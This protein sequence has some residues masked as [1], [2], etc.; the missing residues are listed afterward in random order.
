[1]N[2]KKRRRLRIAGPAILALLA[3]VLISAAPNTPPDDLIRQGNKFVEKVEYE[4]A[5]K[6]YQEAEERGPDPGLIAFNKAAAYWRIGE[7]RIAENHY[8][9]AL[10]DA[11][12][13]IE[14]RTR[15]FYDLGNCLLV[16]GKN[17]DYRLLREA[18]RCYEICL[19]LATEV[20]LRKMATHNLKLAKLRWSEARK[21]SSNP[22]TPNENEPPDTPRQPDQKKKSNKD[23]KNDPTLN[24]DGKDPTKKVDPKTVKE[25]GPDMVEPKA[26]PNNTNEQPRPGR[27]SVPVIP[28]KD[29]LKSL[30][31][32][33]AHAALN[34]VEL[35]LIQIRKRLRGYATIPE[36][37][38]GKD[39]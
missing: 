31:P 14:R 2:A 26:D 17:T 16:Q 38:S 18:I 34:E 3:A 12:A 25:K 1:M 8:R 22:P 21:S 35:R 5:L 36:R 15:A 24:N 33:D 27:G 7:P 23:K 30:D 32:K 20:E 29:D 11:A 39:W 13:P 19:E 28:D 4:E 37:P 10:D 9:M 6:L